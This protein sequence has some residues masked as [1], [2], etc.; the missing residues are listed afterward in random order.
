MSL[1]GGYIA[2]KNIL[3]LLFAYNIVCLVAFALVYYHAGF[4]KH[5]NLPPDVEPSFKN[6]LYYSLATQATCMAGEIT[7]KTTFG[8]GVLSVQITSAYLT[9]MILIVPWVRGSWS[10]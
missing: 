8:R 2:A 9:S 5:F 1:L 4:D 6:A 7:P 10:S 3:L